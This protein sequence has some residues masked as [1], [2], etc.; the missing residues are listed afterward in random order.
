[1]EVYESMGR[2]RPAQVAP[3][4]ARFAQTRHAFFTRGLSAAML[5]RKER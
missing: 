1:M 3:A 5:E 2:G 4:K